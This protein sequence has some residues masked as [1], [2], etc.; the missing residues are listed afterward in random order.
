MIRDVEADR[1]DENTDVKR[2]VDT[3][4]TIRT[5]NDAH[6]MET[7]IATLLLWG[8]VP[9]SQ[10]Q[11]TRRVTLCHSTTPIA[12]AQVPQQTNNDLSPYMIPSNEK[13]TKQA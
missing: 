2:E 3:D 10:I 12:S 6:N 1:E 7:E 11:L 5:N 8:G 9:R 4:R 13:Q